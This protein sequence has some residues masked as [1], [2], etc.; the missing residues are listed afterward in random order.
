MSVYDIFEKFLYQDEERRKQFLPRPGEVSVMEEAFSMYGIFR[1]V[2]W[3]VLSEE[4]LSWEF[5]A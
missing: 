4:A 3:D 5:M 1:A 2:G